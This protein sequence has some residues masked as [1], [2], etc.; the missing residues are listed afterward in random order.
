MRVIVADDSAVIR[1]GVA[2]VRPAE[3]GPELKFA[4][5]P[6]FLRLVAALPPSP[7]AGLR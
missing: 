4:S 7:A 3:S 2:G 6:A 5:Y 1:E